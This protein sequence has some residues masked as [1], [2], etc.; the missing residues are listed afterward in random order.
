M[1]PK[2]CRK[3]ESSKSFKVMI[4]VLIVVAGINVGL[5][6]DGQGNQDTL[7]LVDLMVLVV[8]TIEVFIKMVAH[9]LSSYFRAG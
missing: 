2:L 3:I 9:G 4:T 8:F 1:L 7:Q 5:L 6:I